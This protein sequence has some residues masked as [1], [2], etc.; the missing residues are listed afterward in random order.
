V[1]EAM[2][3]LRSNDEKVANIAYECGFNDLS[4]FSRKFKAIV[5]KSPAA[6]RQCM[7]AFPSDMQLCRGWAPLAP[8][9]ESA[10]KPD[11]SHQN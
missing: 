8:L 9:M 6:Y 4:Y 3:R 2:I 5:G 7:P 11:L 10:N 1:Q